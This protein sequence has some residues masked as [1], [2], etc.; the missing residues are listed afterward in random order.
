MGDVAR[1][2]G[3]VRVGVE[4]VSE[5]NTLGEMEGGF[6]VG[7]SEARLIN[8]SFTCS[9]VLCNSFSSSK[10]TWRG[11][12]AVTDVYWIKVTVEYLDLTLLP[13]STHQYTLSILLNHRQGPFSFLDNTVMDREL[14]LC[15]EGSC[16]E[17]VI[18]KIWR[19]GGL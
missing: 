8:T 6:L 7:E 5:G 12:V 18:F 16:G 1:T 9:S 2:K 17:S 15:Q 3:R 4:G 14:V 11:V 19:E 13:V 10:S